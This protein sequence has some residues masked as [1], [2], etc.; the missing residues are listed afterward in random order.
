MAFLGSYCMS[1][2]M[3]GGR[4][5]V[6]WSRKDDHVG[7]CQVLFSARVRGLETHPMPSSP[8]LCPGAGLH[9]PADVRC[10]MVS[11]QVLTE[12]L[13]GPVV[14]LSIK[15]HSDLESSYIFF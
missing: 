3:V 1:V 4:G 2:V 14:D 15:T 9:P 13:S 6:R 11:T 7:L 8:V 12:G 10:H 5:W